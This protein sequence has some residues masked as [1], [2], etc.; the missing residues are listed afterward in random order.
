MQRV[1]ETELMN[2][3]EQVKA[4]AKANF[5]QPHNEFI[6]RIKRF[7]NQPC[8]NGEGLDLGCGPGDI[9]RRFAKAFPSSRIDAID[10]SQNMIEYAIRTT[11][12][13]LAKQI[14]F[15]CGK[16]PD[17]DLPRTSYDIIYTNSLL[18]HLPNPLIL[19]RTI[20]KYAKSGTKVCVMDLLRPKS[21]IIASALVEQYAKT[22]ADILKLDFYNSLLA[23]FTLEEIQQQLEEALLTFTVEQISDRHVFIS[24][25]MTSPPL[26]NPT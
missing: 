25:T 4:Y 8:F 14:Q 20:K 10:G 19:W 16:L 6:E 15:I 23:A 12:L 24:G 17:E 5:A 3:L 22:E 9:S 13:D 1:L 11:P 2:D 7:V 18:H 26:L 21:N